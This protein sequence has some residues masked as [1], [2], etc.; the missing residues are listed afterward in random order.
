MNG[1][2]TTLGILFSIITLVGL[3]ALFHGAW[4]MNE[5]KRLREEFVSAAPPA[6]PVARQVKLETGIRNINFNNFTFPVEGIDYHFADG[7]WS[8]P[9]IPD[10]GAKINAIAYGQLMANGSEQAVV[11]LSGNWGEG[12]LSAGYI[13]VF[14]YFKNNAWGVATIPGIEAEIKDGTLIVGNIELGEEDPMCCPSLKTKSAYRWDGNS[15]V[16]KKKTKTSQ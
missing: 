10:A 16:L 4:R 13:M 3:I 11:V 5:T 14:D 6:A 9:S 7:K 1:K 8:D 2:R 15:F 12:K